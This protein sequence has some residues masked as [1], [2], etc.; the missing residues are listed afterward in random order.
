M[1]AR[2]PT[3]AYLPT[4]VAI[5]VMVAL[6]PIA[7][8]AK[9][10]EY[11]F[12]VDW[13]SVNFTGTERLAITVAGSIPAPTIEA[14]V[15]DRL[16]VTFHNKMEVETSVHW[17]GVLLPND[18]DGVPYLTTEPIR[19]GKSLTY[20]YPVTHRGTYWYHSHTSLQEQRGVYGAL[21]FH[22]AEGERYPADLERVLVL[23]DWTDEDPHAVFRHL[24]GEDD[25]YSL[26]K[27]TVQSWDKVIGNGGKAINIRL[28]GSWSR[29]GPMD[30]SDV[31]YDAFL[32][33]G[34]RSS[35]LEGVAGGQ[36]VRLRII[37]AS[38]STHHYV[39]FAGGAMTIV[40]SDGMDVEAIEVDRLKLAMG[41]TYDVLVTMPDDGMAYEF[42]ATAK[43]SSGY[44]SAWLGTGHR[45]PAP[46]VSPMNVFLMDHSMHG[47]GMGMEQMHEADPGMESSMHGTTQQD[48]GMKHGGMGHSDMNHES[49]SHGGMKH[50]GMSHEG[51]EHDGM[52]HGDMNYESMSHGD[53]KHDGMNHEGMEHDGVKHEGMSHGDMKHDG[54]NHEGM[55]H[56]G[57]KHEGM[58]H[59]DMKHDGMNHEGMEHDGVKHE[60]MSHGDMKH[61]GMKHTDTTREEMQ[62]DHSRGHGAEHMAH[63][64]P[65]AE[66]GVRMLHEYAG[67]RAVENTTL[68]PSRPLRTVPLRLTGDMES[69]VWSFNDKTLA[70][71]DKVRIRK[72][73][74]VLFVLQNETMM[75]HPL[76]LHGHF[77][78]VLNG[79]GDYSPL[80]HTVNVPPMQTLTI[81]FAADED[82][83]W[84]F[85]CH[86]LYHMKAGMARVVSY[87]GTRENRV[88]DRRIA[89]TSDPWFAFG[90]V[91]VQSNMAVGEF[92]MENMNNSWMFEFER[93]E[94]D[95]LAAELL[96]ERGLSRFLGFYFGA[97]YERESDT[98]EHAG[99]LDGDSHRQLSPEEA[100]TEDDS[101]AVF[102]LHYV[103]PLMVE[104]DLRAND[105]GDLQLD[106]E[107]DLQLT[108]RL[109]FAWEWNTEDEYRL[110]LTYELSKGVGF[111]ANTDS[112]YDTGV[113]LR[114][115]F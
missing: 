46:D 53:M 101:R 92:W 85:H 4:L 96:Y 31:G 113:G 18:Q 59:G 1:T 45:M 43:D 89:A 94:D 66:M 40:A 105:E 30:I 72:G 50:G 104:A 27:G 15:G 41:E 110:E 78:R 99:D 65:D 26:K 68:D 87:E 11:E 57:V 38:S 47:A 16:R 70:E 32:I 115:K 14:T 69:Y 71:A 39:Q 52:K 90:E 33:N 35:D 64:T 34:R 29:M 22:P 36:T 49:M 5:V 25:Y 88:F 107:S 86:N 19:P 91:A 114:I 20:E 95:S 98:E 10:V 63:G 60:G 108:S 75:E 77:F 28:K 81:E 23:S 7:A 82:Q 42:R 37:N 61:S 2:V 44:A 109:N 9:L 8:H 74:T 58:S 6:V 93:N 21:V 100:G 67:L 3:T 54:M 24:K 84:F 55:E 56:D 12:D 51:M 48:Q 106:L 80:K 73:E 112:E 83:D 17:H 62:Q 97:E 111:V 76:H 79:Q 103:L 13:Q 102:G